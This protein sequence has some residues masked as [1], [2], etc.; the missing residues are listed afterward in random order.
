MCLHQELTGAVSGYTCVSF[1]LQPSPRRQMTTQ[2]RR[3]VA[4][5]GLRKPTVCSWTYSFVTCGMRVAAVNAVAALPFKQGLVIDQQSASPTLPE[6]NIVTMTSVDI[7]PQKSISMK[8][9]MM[10]KHIVL[11]LCLGKQRYRELKWFNNLWNE[12]RFTDSHSSDTGQPNKHQ[13]QTK[14]PGCFT[15][16]LFPAM[17]EKF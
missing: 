9:I 15:L 17:P 11:I 5:R 6:W 16:Y 10:S 1:S 14:L 8:F 2:G 3:Q 7:T 13:K 4:A 12:C